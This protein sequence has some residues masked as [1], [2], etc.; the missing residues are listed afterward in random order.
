MFVFINEYQIFRTHKLYVNQ[1][2]D[3]NR[4]AI[5]IDHSSNASHNRP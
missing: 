1:S 5:T 2:V 4:K 3:V